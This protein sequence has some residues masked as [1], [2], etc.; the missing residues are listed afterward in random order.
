MN[1]RGGRRQT[2]L[3][4]AKNLSELIGMKKKIH[5]SSDLKRKQTPQQAERHVAGGA[6]FD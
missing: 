1:S 3:V 4:D 5:Q 6:V 2:R